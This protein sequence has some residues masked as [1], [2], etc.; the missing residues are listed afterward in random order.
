VQLSLF[1]NEGTR[2]KGAKVECLEIE[3]F[4]C[5]RVGIEI[6]LEPPIKE[7]AI[8]I[9]GADAAAHAIG[10]F[11]NPYPVAQFVKPHRAR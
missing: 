1:P 5:F 2:L 3:K 8:D 7:K 6:N 10:R 4:S 9:V 11:E